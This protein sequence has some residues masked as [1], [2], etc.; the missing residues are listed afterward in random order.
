MLLAGNNFQDAQVEKNVKCELR[1]RVGINGVNT[2]P[3]ACT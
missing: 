1:N 3:I 2:Y